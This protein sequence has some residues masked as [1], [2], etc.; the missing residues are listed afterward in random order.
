MILFT[1]T[2]GQVRQSYVCATYRGKCH[3]SFEIDSQMSRQRQTHDIN[4][5]STGH[6]FSGDIIEWHYLLLL[7]SPVL[8]SLRGVYPNR[9]MPNHVTCS[10]QTL[11]L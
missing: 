9:N 2:S 5:G 10:N 11:S 8:T 7:L 3:P 6:I 4:L 1:K